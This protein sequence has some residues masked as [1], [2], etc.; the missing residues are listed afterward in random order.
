MS[1]TAEFPP[2]WP[3]VEAKTKQVENVRPSTIQGVA[4]QFRQASKDSADHTVALRN[5]TAALGGGTWSGPQADAFFDYVKKI[6]DAGQKVNDHLDEVAN[7]LG[8][9][10]A[11]LDRTQKEVQQ[12]HDD[13]HNKIDAANRQAQSA[14]DAAQAQIDAVNAHRDGATMPAQTPDA[15]IA[16]NLQNTT[17]IADD[18]KSQI[19]SKLNAAN[20]EIQRVMQ[21]VQKDVEGGYSSVPPLGT[22]PAAM[23]STGGLYGG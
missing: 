20:Q 3:D 2:N 6:G 23:Q 12:L 16:Q 18:A 9:L 7:E 10:Q 11:F 22:A 5:A 15:I 14:A 13:A 4:D 17:A 19:E 1:A 21:L 8:N